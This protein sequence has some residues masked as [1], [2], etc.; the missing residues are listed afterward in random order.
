MFLDIPVDSKKCNTLAAASN[1]ALKK[2]LIVT[3][4][5]RGADGL[6]IIRRV[7]IANRAEIASR[8]VATCRRLGIISIAI[9][10]DL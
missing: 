8:V 2:S 5:P 7:L 6:P 4:T 3:P 9:Y 1:M 10:T